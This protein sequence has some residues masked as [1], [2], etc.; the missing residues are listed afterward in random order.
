[1]TA[2]KI[3]DTRKDNRQRE[4]VAGTR[5]ALWHQEGIDSAVNHKIVLAGS[6]QES[7]DAVR[8]SETAWLSKAA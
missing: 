6:K 2:D 5:V 8:S 3:Q 4:V 1:M 7:C